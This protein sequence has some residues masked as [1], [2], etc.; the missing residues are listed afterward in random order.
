MNLY[1]CVHI[2]NQH[3]GPAEEQSPRWESPSTAC[4]VR[5]RTQSSSVFSCLSPL[6]G[7]VLVLRVKEGQCIDFRVGLL[8]RVTSVRVSRGVL[9]VTSFSFPA[10]GHWLVFSLWLLWIKL[11]L[12]VCV[13]FCGHIPSFV[14][15]VQKH[16]HT[17]TH[18]QEHMRACEWKC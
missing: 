16:T 8:S 10:D 7:F 4:P 11:L 12:T 14:V 2:G 18:T 3:I 6:I 15:C 17:H 5:T 1:T 13:P 9:Y